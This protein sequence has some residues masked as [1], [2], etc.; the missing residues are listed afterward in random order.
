MRLPKRLRYRLR[1]LRKL[2]KKGGSGHK[3]SPDLRIP[4]SSPTI[5]HTN[6]KKYDRRKSKTNAKKEIKENTR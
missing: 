3:V 1:K 6:K 4:I 5:T 2:L